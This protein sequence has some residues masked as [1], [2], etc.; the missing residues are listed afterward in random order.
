MNIPMD[1][2]PPN[3]Q[4][5]GELGRGKSKCWIGLLDYRYSL[6]R[7]GELKRPFEIRLMGKQM[8]RDKDV[9]IQ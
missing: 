7:R 9:W 1:A 2:L 8:L 4:T 5:V 6:M 3:G